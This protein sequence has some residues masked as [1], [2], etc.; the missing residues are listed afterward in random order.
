MDLIVTKFG[1]LYYY[2]SMGILV[3]KDILAITLLPIHTMSL[4]YFIAP[5][6]ISIQAGWSKSEYLWT[7]YSIVSRS[8]CTWSVYRNV[9]SFSYL[10]VKDIMQSDCYEAGLMTTGKRPHALFFLNLNEP[11]CFI[12]SS[13]WSTYLIFLPA[14]LISWWEDFKSCSSN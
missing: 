13:V 3:A 10:F 6:I 9:I 1:S 8:S 14:L 12:K 7:L 2:R 5:S 4:G 11:T